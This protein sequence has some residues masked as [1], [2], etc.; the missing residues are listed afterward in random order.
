MDKPGSFDA[1]QCGSSQVHLQDS[2]LCIEGEIA[3]RRKIV[4]ISIFLQGDLQRVPSILQLGVLHRQ[5]D[6]VDLQ[7][8]EQPLGVPG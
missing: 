5:F 7:F 2:P 6:L 4:E 3:D 8:V 1:K